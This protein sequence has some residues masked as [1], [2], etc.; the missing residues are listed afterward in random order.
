MT[1]VGTQFSHIW[2][3]YVALLGGGSVEL[4]GSH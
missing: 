2:Y 4:L 3:E 1:T